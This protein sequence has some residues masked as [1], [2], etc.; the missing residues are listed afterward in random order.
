MPE[1]DIEHFSGSIIKKTEDGTEVMSSYVD[2]SQGETLVSAAAQSEKVEAATGNEEETKTALQD[3]TKT[4]PEEAKPAQIKPG[5]AKPTS[6]PVV[7]S[8]NR[9]EQ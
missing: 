7:D 5:G 8:G 4:Q 1:N 6:T 3:A 2:A 9:N